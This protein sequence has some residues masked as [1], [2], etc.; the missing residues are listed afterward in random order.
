VLHCSRAPKTKVSSLALY[1]C[2]VSTSRRAVKTCTQVLL[3]LCHAVFS[4][5]LWRAGGCQKNLVM[6]RLSM[7]PCLGY[8]RGF[9]SDKET[10]F[11]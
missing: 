6:S 4:S 9:R 5:A 3:E 1:A 10:H 7:I 8:L 11:S 2:G